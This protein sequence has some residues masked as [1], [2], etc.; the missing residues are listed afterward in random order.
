MKNKYKIFSLLILSFTIFACMNA[1]KASALLVLQGG[2]GG[3]GVSDFYYNGSCDNH[4]ILSG[5]LNDPEG[6]VVESYGYKSGSAP[7]RITNSNLD[8]NYWLFVNNSNIKTASGYRFSDGVVGVNMPFSATG[9]VSW[10]GVNANIAFFDPIGLATNAPSAFNNNGGSINC[11]QTY[12]SYTWNQNYYAHDFVFEPNFGWVLF[13]GY[14]E[15]Q[16]VNF[17][18]S[19]Y[20]NSPPYGYNTG[21]YWVLTSDGPATFSS[22]G[23]TSYPSNS[24]TFN[25][26]TIN[27]SSGQKFQ[28]GFSN[29]VNAYYVEPK[30]NLTTTASNNNPAN[31]F[32]NTNTV[33]N[34]NL[35]SGVS[36]KTSIANT[37][38]YTNTITEYAIQA[39]GGTLPIPLSTSTSTISA[40]S[41]DSSSSSTIYTT[42][43]PIN[44]KSSYKYNG[45]YVNLVDG[46]SVCV[47]IKS[48]PSA[49]APYAASS[50]TS[51]SCVT[52]S[53]SS[54]IATLS[55]SDV[56]VDGTNETIT[57]TVNNQTSLPI[58]IGSNG[59]S[60]SET[61]TGGTFNQNS[62]Y[63]SWPFGVANTINYPAN[64]S[65][66]SIGTGSY[67]WHIGQLPYYALLG[68]YNVS[69]S[70]IGPNGFQSSANCI[71]RVVVKPYF[72]VYGGSIMTGSGFADSSGSCT[73]T[74]NLNSN[75]ISFNSGTGS[76]TDQA[77][78]ASGYVY[79]YGSQNNTSGLN[80]LTFANNLN[81]NIPN[82][83]GGAY[84]DG[85][86]CMPDYYDT[87][88]NG[89]NSTTKNVNFSVTQT[90]DQFVA[91]IAP[92]MVYWNGFEYVSILS[93]MSEQNNYLTK[94][95]SST[96]SYPTQ[97]DYQNVFIADSSYGDIHISANL[98]Q[99]DNILPNGKVPYLYIISKGAD[100]YIDN[101]VSEVDAVLISEPDSGNGGNIYTC[102]EKKS[103]AQ[104][105][106]VG[107]CNTPLTVKGAL[108][109]SKVNLLRSSQT[110]TGT[111]L[112]NENGSSENAINSTSGCEN[113]STFKGGEQVCFSPAL[114]MINPYTPIIS[115]ASSVTSN[116]TTQTTSSYLDYLQNLPGTL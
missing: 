59:W 90:I 23:P 85:I 104:D 6:V 96:G 20:N 56:Y 34:F 111:I 112:N 78:F 57:Y 62:P 113:P 94:T 72:K 40:S 70:L 114:W 87:I 43:V 86:K 38:N 28:N 48:T 49:N 37:F 109:A 89:V 29:I 11:A 100:I 81:L 4:N 80:N 13:C 7:A 64:I 76:S 22:K 44:I 3:S 108:I 5:S 107:G 12:G 115:G 50:S 42:T 116:N 51:I 32:V 58:T 24:Y 95:V 97:N 68:T 99:P 73:T 105:F 54:G 82:L 98:I 8:N 83:L 30:Y 14:S 46:D 106:N 39:S 45:A 67:S 75:I 84:S 18:F 53:N 55:C 102:N 47:Q 16:A 103:S 88:L 63:S 71:A 9:G 74:N 93:L 36:N 26:N 101:N 17:N 31:K 69:L 21:G 19:I 65:P 60:M 33:V 1:S 10:S 91:H 25:Y 66:N 92:Q 15:G 41:I 52:I 79:G 61:I 77:V 2:G 27:G 110:Y 35:T